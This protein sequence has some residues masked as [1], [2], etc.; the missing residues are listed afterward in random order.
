MIT[1]H[2][3]FDGGPGS[4]K[5]TLLA[6]A[7]NAGY[8]VYHIAI[9]SESDEPLRFYCTR[10]GLERVHF[11]RFQ[12]D[13]SLD[14]EG[15]GIQFRAKAATAVERFLYRGKIGTGKEPGTDFGDPR[16]WGRDTLVA[17]DTL[18]ALGDSCEVRTLALDPSTREG[19]H[20]W[21]AAQD[22]EAVAQ[23]GR[24]R[25][26]GCHFLLLSHVQLI[27]PKAET[28][29][30]DE[31]ELQKKVKRERAQL[32][33]TG[34][35]PCAMTPK[36]SRNFAHHFPFVFFVE[37][38]EKETE[39]N[40]SGRVIRTKPVPGYQIKCPLDV[41]DKLPIENGL[42]TILKKLEAT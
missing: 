14:D 9:G 24:V 15:N 41:G 17:I 30:K 28:G 3:L 10:E 21:A 23:L 6:A 7:A 32:E 16:G 2:A 42:V 31:T 22:Q 37:G 36:I 4:G 12:D 26:R 8:N 20:L 34:F 27:S 11:I 5:T 19:K 35:F 40:P 25:L 33:E 38:G 13:I 18:T 1:L 29:Y 39:R